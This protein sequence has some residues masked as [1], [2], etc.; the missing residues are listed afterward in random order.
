M[1]FKEALRAKQIS[2]E[3]LPYRINS[4]RIY[5]EEA[6]VLFLDRLQLAPHHLDKLLA[7][8]A[9]ADKLVLALPQEGPEEQLYQ[10]GHLAVVDA[11][12]TYQ[13]AAALAA[14]IPQAKLAFD[15]AQPPALPAEAEARLINL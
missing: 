2:A 4:W 12:S 1:N 5:G 6:L 8:Q 3:A 9:L 14:R 7:Y 15:L 11:V 10:A 13:D